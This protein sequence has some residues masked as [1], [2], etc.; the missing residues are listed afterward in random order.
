MVSITIRSNRHNYLLRVKGAQ[1]AT[2]SADAEVQV[3]NGEQESY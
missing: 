1:G 3:D 2:E